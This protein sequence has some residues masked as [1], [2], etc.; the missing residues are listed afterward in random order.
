MPSAREVYSAF[1]SHLDRQEQILVS[2]RM[3]QSQLVREFETSSERLSNIFSALFPTLDTLPLDAM[4]EATKSPRDYRH[5]AT[6]LRAQDVHKQEERT[7]LLAAYGSPQALDDQ[8]TK[9]ES[10]IAEVADKTREVKEGLE[11][12]RLIVEPNQKRRDGLVTFFRKTGIEITDH[13][14]DAYRKFAL[15]KWLSSKQW[16]AGHRAVKDFHQGGGASIDQDVVIYEAMVKRQEELVSSNKNN[17]REYVALHQEVSQLSQLRKNVAQLE[18]EIL[19]DP[20]IHQAVCAHFVEQLTDEDVAKTFGQKFPAEQ[21]EGLMIGVL[22]HR[23]LHT[24]Y[25]NLEALRLQAE[26]ALGQVQEPLPKLKRLVNNAP[27]RNI[28]VN[29]GEMETQFGAFNQAATGYVGKVQNARRVLAEFPSTYRRPSDTVI[30]SAYQDDIY[31]QMNF[32]LLNMMAMDS[33][34]PISHG[35]TPAPDCGSALSST[36]SIDG[37]VSFGVPTI[38]IGSTSCVPDFGSSLSL[39]SIP[40]FDTGSFSVPSPTPTYDGGGGGYGG[41]GGGGGGSCGG[42]DGGGCCTSQI[43]RPRRGAMNYQRSA[44]IHYRPF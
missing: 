41:D 30:R 23:N 38:D 13:N 29:L 16:R 31:S 21:I 14:A 22:Q 10:R 28:D 4:T 20:K 44:T 32:M 3:E 8:V 1:Q 5:M 11:S 43:E 42:G 25:D 9:L 33:S 18:A 19:G 39:P 40:S 36:P 7:T 35:H 27:S 34:A 12:V 2:V 6:S 17:N 26:K 15:G 37:G 24:I